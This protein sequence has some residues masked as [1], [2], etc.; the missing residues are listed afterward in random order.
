MSRHDP[1]VPDQ[2][3]PL[4]TALQGADAVVIGANHSAFDDLL[5]R[6][7]GEAVVVDPWNALGAGR[8]FATAG[9]LAAAR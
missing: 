4:D 5:P 8:V 2:S 9:T 1:H 7:P 6:L 3:E